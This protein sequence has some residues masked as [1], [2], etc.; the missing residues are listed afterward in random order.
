MMG[1]AVAGEDARPRFCMRAPM[2]LLLGVMLSAGGVG[3]RCSRAP[4]RAA[5]APCDAA[6]PATRPASMPA[7][8]KPGQP[9]STPA[10][11]GAAYL[12]RV[13]AFADGKGELGPLVTGLPEF[14]K[15]RAHALH[16]PLEEEKTTSAVRRRLETFV[17]C[18]AVKASDPGRCQAAAPLGEKSVAW[19]RGEY[20]FVRSL[21]AP[22][23]R[24]GT[25]AP[26]ALGPAAEHLGLK[27]E[28]L[29]KICEALAQKQPGKCP[30]HPGFGRQCIAFAS[31]DLKKCAPAAGKP[32]GGQAPEA[33]CRS[34]V[35]AL[36]ALRA[37][38]ATLV[39][40]GTDLA[41]LAAA[42]LGGSPTCGEHLVASF[43]RTLEVTQ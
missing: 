24:S 5:A 38:D 7:R 35:S 32:A 37:G 17:A 33:D 1:R 43:R 8:F 11:A 3:C 18:Q 26:D 36:M 22:S 15:D 25:C 30:A 39:T 23:L 40:S 34:D 28:S 13:A 2:I 10:V 16:Q 12:E 6:A 19:C 14:A 4:E 27:P 31:H 29:K 20:A 9:A 42:V 41:A 21:L